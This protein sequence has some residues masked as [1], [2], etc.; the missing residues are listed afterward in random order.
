MGTTTGDFSSITSSLRG[1][2][3]FCIEDPCYTAYISYYFFVGF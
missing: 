2:S 1:L 3:L